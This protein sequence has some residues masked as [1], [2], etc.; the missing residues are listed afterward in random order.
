VLPFDDDDVVA[1][2]MERR[3]SNPLSG[4]RLPKLAIV[5]SSHGVRVRASWYC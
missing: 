5:A 3:G 1:G 4:R 2:P